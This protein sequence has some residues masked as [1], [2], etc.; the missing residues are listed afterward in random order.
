MV[1]VLCSKHS[2]QMDVWVRL[3]LSIQ[4]YAPMSKF[5]KACWLRPSGKQ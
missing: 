2:V 4:K 5:G 3:P 1:D